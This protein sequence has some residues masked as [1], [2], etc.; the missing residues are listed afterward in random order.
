MSTVV[1]VVPFKFVCPSRDG[2]LDID[3]LDESA[4]ETKLEREVR[5][6]YHSYR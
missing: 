6:Q 3:S 2:L 5:E 1:I 4:G